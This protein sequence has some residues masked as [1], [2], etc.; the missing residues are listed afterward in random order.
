MP[1]LALSIEH[2]I[3]MQLSLFLSLCA[4]ISV[5]SFPCSYQVPV[6]IHVCRW[7]AHVSHQELSHLNVK[8]DECLAC[9]W[10]Q[11]RKQDL[12]LSHWWEV[13]QEQAQLVVCTSKFAKVLGCKGQWS[14]VA[15]DL[16]ALVHSS[17][18]GQRAFGH[19]NTFVV[20]AQMQSMVEKALADLSK[21]NSITKDVM[22]ALQD[23]LMAEAANKSAASALASKRNI[24]CQFRDISIT[25]QV[26]NFQEDSMPCKAPIPLCIHV[27][28]H[29]MVPSVVQA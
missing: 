22:E 12:D 1:T 15:A 16:D 9:T 26:S 7:P 3:H 5:H 14:D 6:C 4:I 17:L 25:F 24:T 20:G 18:I 10:E 29:L 8:F 28:L 19:A 23:S 2:I 13:Y 27:L 11:M 21:K